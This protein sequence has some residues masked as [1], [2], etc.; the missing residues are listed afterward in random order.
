MGLHH[1]CTSNNN[2]H[3][4]VY[5]FFINHVQGKSCKNCVYSLKCCDFLNSASSAA[6]LVFYLPF[7]GP[8][9]KSGVHTEEKPREERVRNLFRFF[10]KNTRFNEH[11]VSWCV[12][13]Q[14][15]ILFIMTA[16][17]NG[18]EVRSHASRGG[19]L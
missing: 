10:R 2:D 8:S 14:I 13:I 6:A 11:P 15:C 12:Y 19:N 3:Q 4:Q 18:E 1:R 9:M 16:Y 5:L 17:N 7:S